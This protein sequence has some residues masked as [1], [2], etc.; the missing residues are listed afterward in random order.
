M[1]I[2][3]IH[4]SHRPGSSS[5]DDII[6]ENEVYLLE[7]NNHRV[8]KII[9]TNDEFY[10]T[11]PVKKIITILQIP[12]SFSSYK[13]VRQIIRLEKPD[14]IH[15]HN[16]FPLLSP[17]IYYAADSEGIPVIQTLHDF[18]FIC[19]VAFLIRDGKICEECINTSP[20]RSIRYG[21]FKGSRLKTLP[22]ALMI[23]LHQSLN[24]FKVR[25]SAYICLTEFQ[26]EIF[27]KSG[28]DK[29]RIF[30]KPNFIEDTFNPS[31]N[32]VGDYVIFIGRLGAEKG[33][34]TL[35]EAWRALPDIPLKI[36]GSGPESLE[37][38]KLVERFKINNVEFTGIL[39][40]Y[41]CMNMLRNS[42]FLIMPSICYETFGLVIIEAFSHAKPVIASK[43][44][45]MAE[46]VKDGYTGF[47]FKPGDAEDL[48]K[49]VKMLFREPKNCIIMGQ[50]ARR[51]YEEKYTP[52][53]N[54]EL[55][56][57]IYQKVIS[58]KANIHNAFSAYDVS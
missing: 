5:G 18:R 34:K 42:R 21:C 52:D 14:I 31:K 19:P 48:R 56:M 32:T 39:K 26:R 43:L 2:I 37:I 1:K 50:N 54:Y 28:F 16:V 40:H 38:K 8:V 53:K 47:L 10:K 3:L 58:D 49:K 55:L 36:I 29:K 51:E 30:V 35:I 44:G 6:F 9:S 46:L 41:E 12:W 13:K 24:T 22:L 25:I 23:K 33:I 57:A 4:N 17:S 7:R 45:A 20:L 27:I 11:A 15:V